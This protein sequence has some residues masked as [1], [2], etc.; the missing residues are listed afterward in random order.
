MSPSSSGAKTTDSDAMCG[1][2]VHRAPARVCP[3][4]WSGGERMWAGKT[5]PSYL[6]LHV[7]D[8]VVCKSQLC[9]K[10]HTLGPRAVGIHAW[11]PRGWGCMDQLFKCLSCVA[12]RELGLETSEI[13]ASLTQEA[14]STYV[15]Q[16]CKHA[17]TSAR[18]HF[19]DPAQTGHAVWAPFPI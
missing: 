16:E 10:G 12:A 9:L 5:I 14:C 11:V 8:I 6:F 19:E 13:P 15:F 2:S 18:R 1:T 17:H 7:R 4:R 3:V